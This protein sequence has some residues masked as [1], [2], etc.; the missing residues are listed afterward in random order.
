MSG[1]T[2]GARATSW[3][4]EV[5]RIE[6]L[7]DIDFNESLIVELEHT[8]ALNTVPRPLQ[9]H[10]PSFKSCQTTE[11][12][13]CNKHGWPAVSVTGGECQLQCEHCR[14]NILKPMLPATTPA[15]LW[16]L[17]NELIENGAQGILLTGGSNHRNEIDYQRFWP[18]M[19]RLKAKYPWFH[20]ACHTALLDD[21]KAQCMADAGVDVAMMDVI[22]AR[23][24]IRRVYHLKR[25]VEDFADSLAALC[26]TSMRVVPHIVLGLHFGKLLGEWRAL[27]IIKQYPVAALVLVAVMPHFA[28]RRFQLQPLDASAIGRFVQL[29]RREL[30]DVALSLGCARPAGQLKTEIDTYAVMAGVD[31]IAHPAEGIVQLAQCLGRDVVV[32]SACCSVAMKQKTFTQPHDENNSDVRC[33][34]VVQQPVRVA[35]I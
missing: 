16:R 35:R 24:T 3:L 25:E 33:D 6:V 18:V 10:N 5:R 8:A 30:P 22:G 11:L 12:S 23:D 20:I 1:E 19:N 21:G 27:E 28:T 29:A 2:K 13:S 32:S 34:F 17:V 14:A 4:D 15:A 31:R 26:R 7:E 9:I